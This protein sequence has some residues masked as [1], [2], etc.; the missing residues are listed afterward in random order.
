MII[1]TVEL[2]HN[3]ENYRL[4]NQLGLAGNLPIN[5][6]A[7]LRDACQKH[8]RGESTLRELCQQAVERFPEHLEFAG[9]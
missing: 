5:V 7:H 2:L 9:F 8:F 4:C 6:Q 1:L 3:W